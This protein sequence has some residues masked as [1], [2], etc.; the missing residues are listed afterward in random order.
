MDT[1]II[2]IEY[3]KSR[4]KSY[5]Q[6]ERYAKIFS[7]FTTGD[8]R[9]ALRIHTVEEMFTFPSEFFYILQQSAKWVGTIIRYNGTVVLDKPNKMMY[10][11]KDIHQCYRNYSSS[12]KKRDFCNQTGNGCRRLEDVNLN[13]IS[14]YVFKRWYKF[15]F[16]EENN[17]YKIDKPYIKELVAQDA[18]ERMLSLC[19]AFSLDIINIIIDLLPDT[20]DLNSGTWMIIYEQILGEKG[21]MNIPFSVE[22]SDV[23]P[24]D[25]PV[26]EA[27]KVEKPIHEM[28]ESEINEK[29][30]SGEWG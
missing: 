27:P 23:F 2:E 3:L 1:P 15:G 6:V 16:F 10:K 11:L 13:G 9:H 5:A 14:G 4:S 26:Y 21:Y 24:E 29:L 19:P 18:R 17:V 7:D 8:G 20:L 30:D 28:S 22:L 12:I 25:V